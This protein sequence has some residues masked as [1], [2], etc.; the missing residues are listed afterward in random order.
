MR[1]LLGTW[2]L[3]LAIWVPLMLLLDVLVLHRLRLTGAALWT[4]TLVP[5]CQAV[6]L[7]SLAAPLGLSRA[8]AQL[9]RNIRDRRIWIPWGLALVGSG[10]AMVGD[11][12]R[13]LG[14]TA[15]LLA[16]LAAVRF[17]VAA[18]RGGPLARARIA[19]V[20]L[21]LLLLL[22]SA[23]P[24]VVRLDGWTAVAAPGGTVAVARMLL[25]P[26]ALGALFVSLF[27]VQSALAPGHRTA[28]TWLGAA[29]GAG[30]LAL[31][32]RWLPL[33]LE[34][35][36]PGGEPLAPGVFLLFATACVASAALAVGLPDPQR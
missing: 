14:L 18:R 28:A 31:I 27:A 25:V 4:A 21:A 1:E 26:G 16:L 10:V 3:L 20:T 12:A 23:M 33:R 24:F 17:L 34:V 19:T 5:A 32:V 30:G 8:V 6:A 29:A 2:V 15:G 36:L 7:E 13:R 11:G 9:L 22:G 35:A